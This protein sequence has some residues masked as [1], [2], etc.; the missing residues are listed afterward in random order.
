MINQWAQMGGYTINWRYTR[1]R[2][3]PPV[4]YAIPIF[5]DEELS[6]YYGM[7]STK[8]GAREAASEKLAHSSY[9]IGHMEAFR[10]IDLADTSHLAVNQVTDD[11]DNG[12]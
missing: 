3:Q 4:F 6:E 5:N 8:K 10:P 1:P 12:F 2:M 7:G 11:H 9:T